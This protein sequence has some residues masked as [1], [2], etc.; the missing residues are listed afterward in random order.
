MPKSLEYLLQIGEMLRDCPSEDTDVVQEGQHRSGPLLPVLPQS[1]FR[2]ATLLRLQ[3]CVPEGKLTESVRS[4]STEET[5]SG[6]GRCQLTY[7]VDT[8]EKMLRL[9]PCAGR[10]FYPSRP[11]P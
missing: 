11:G 1:S 2:K 10:V 7:S 8:C 6:I 9:P 3:V 4:I 5:R